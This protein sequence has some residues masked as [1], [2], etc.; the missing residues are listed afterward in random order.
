MNKILVLEDEPMLQDMIKSYLESS[1]FK[2]TVCDNYDEALDLAYENKFDLFIFDVKIIGGSGFELLKE[3]RSS[4]VNTPCIFETSLN[5][6]DDIT[7]GFNSGC[8]DYIKKPFE[9]AE[10]KL[11]VENILKR[12]FSHIA[13]NEL[14]KID[15][16][17]EFDMI[18]KCLLKDG[19]EVNLAKKEIELLVLFLQNKG[20]ILSRDTIYSS[21]WGYDE[22]PSELSLR[23]YISNL[24]KII[25]A[26]KIISHSK[27]GYEY[28]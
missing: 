19:V 23:V 25:G 18:K 12:N 5:G 1:D 21:I 13:K 20:R 17:I 10:L 9:L 27:T 7:A 16:E 15:D 3:L 24:R 26:N 6:I 4:G 8:D 2:I 11:R 28:V 22:T 14:I